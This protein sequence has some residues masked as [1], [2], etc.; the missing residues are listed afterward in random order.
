MQIKE[1]AENHLIANVKSTTTT[2]TQ[3]RWLNVIA[4]G[5]AWPCG[6]KG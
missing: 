4:S 1:Q 5:C 6:A 2:T 3:L